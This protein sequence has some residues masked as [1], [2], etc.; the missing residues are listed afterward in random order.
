LKKWPYESTED[1]KY[2]K[3]KDEFFKKSGNGW[4]LSVDVSQTK[5]RLTGKLKK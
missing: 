2:I 4:W 5:T 3:D 1:P